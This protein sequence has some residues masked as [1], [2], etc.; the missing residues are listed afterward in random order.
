MG[1]VT[2]RVTNT[3]DRMLAKQCTIATV[4]NTVLVPV[5][6][7]QTATLAME[8]AQNKSSLAEGH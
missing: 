2:E 1:Q 8:R 4:T 3:L 5:M 7:T 6:V